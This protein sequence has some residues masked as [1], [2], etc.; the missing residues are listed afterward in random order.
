[1]H[2][3]NLDGNANEPAIFLRSDYFGGRSKIGIP[4]SA[5]NKPLFVIAAALFSW[6]V[7]GLP[8]VNPLGLRILP[9]QRTESL[10]IQASSSNLVAKDNGCVHDLAGVQPSRRIRDQNRR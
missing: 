6:P 8:L 2:L 3:A 5:M 9:F 10:G 4:L 7:Y 1:M